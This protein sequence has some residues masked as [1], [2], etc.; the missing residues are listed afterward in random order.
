MT[1]E[2]KTWK[3]KCRKVRYISDIVRIVVDEI[4]SSGKID[5]G[6]SDGRL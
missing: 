3:I 5:D 4:G 6:V 1:D 2:L